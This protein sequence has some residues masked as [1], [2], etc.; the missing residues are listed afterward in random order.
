VYGGTLAGWRSLLTVHGASIL[1]GQ[2]LL[3]ADLSGQLPSG[4]L[5]ELARQAGLPTATYLLPGD[6]GRSGLLARLTP[7]QFGDA[8]TEAIHAG[9]PADP[10]NAPPAAYCTCMAVQAGARSARTEMLTALI[11]QW[12]TIQVRTFLSMR[13]CWLPGGRCGRWSATRRSLRCPG[14]TCVR[15]VAALLGAGNYRVQKGG[16]KHPLTAHDNA[17]GPRLTWWTLPR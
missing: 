11:I 7:A 8:L 10:Q 1:A 4:Q 15:L 3:V 9:G 6:L 2:P 16:G 14:R 12:L 17:R 5:A 13:S